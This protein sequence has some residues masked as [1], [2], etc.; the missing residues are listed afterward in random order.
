MSSIETDIV[1]VVGTCRAERAGYAKRLAEVTGRTVFTEVRLGQSPNPVDE[2]IALAAWVQE[3]GAV[4]E[5]PAD[6][7]VIEFIHAVHRDN[8]RSSL[9]D[10]VCVA[11]AAHL[12]DDFRRDTYAGRPVM[13]GS[14]E[15]RTVT[16]EYVAHAVLTMHQIEYASKIVL[17]NWQR[18][19][20]PNLAALMALVSHLNP[21][22]ALWLDQGG[23]EPDHPTACDGAS[24]NIQ[25]GWVSVINGTHAPRMSDARIGTLHYEQLRPFHPERLKQLI[26]DRIEKSE[27]GTVIRSAGFCRLASRAQTLARWEHVGPVFS[28]LPLAHHGKASVNALMQAT[29]QNLAFFG[30]DLESG[31]LRAALDEAVLTDGELTAGVEAWRGYPDVFP[32]WEA[33][34]EPRE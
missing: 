1:A 26:D 7:R 34:R 20:T 24:P 30:I 9:S 10:I 2:A 3:T 25:P 31:T 5:L 6:T 4:M 13:Q 27:F 17:V 23:L 8:S 16:T 14:G 12:I 21:Q 29:G 18:M 15:E 22:A 33:I 11:D 32:V 19:G 28:M